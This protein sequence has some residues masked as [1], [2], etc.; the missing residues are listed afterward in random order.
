MIQAKQNMFSLNNNPDINLEGLDLSK[1]LV[2]MAA[3]IVH[4]L[5]NRILDRWS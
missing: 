2:N 4:S 5:G 1:K 3:M